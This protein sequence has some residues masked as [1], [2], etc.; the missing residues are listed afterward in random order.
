[1]SDLVAPNATISGAAGVY[2]NGNDLYVTGLFGQS[3]EKFNATTGVQD[4]SFNVSG[5]AFPQGII[6]SPDGQGMLVGILGDLP[7]GGN[8]SEYS[9]SGQFLGVFASPNPG[10]GFTE[11]T[12]FVHVPEPTS[13]ALAGLGLAMLG[14]VIRRRAAR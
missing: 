5:L 2:L 9:Y 14:F 4:N 10:S 12:A 8:I 6:A 7:G 13:L 3:L 11:A 1:M